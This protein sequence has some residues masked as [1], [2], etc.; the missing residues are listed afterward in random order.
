MNKEKFFAGLPFTINDSNLRP[1]IILV[2]NELTTVIK[3][4]FE[5]LDKD[6]NLSNVT[7]GHS[8]VDASV[9]LLSGYD[10]DFSMDF[11]EEI[12]SIVNS[13]G[14]A[15]PNAEITDVMDNELFEEWMFAPELNVSENTQMIL[16]SGGLYFTCQFE[17]EFIES[18]MFDYAEFGI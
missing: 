10:T 16:T 17:T 15:D 8:V 12:K 2:N 6:P 4:Y 1:F 13:I 7:V 14:D 5:L 11:A 9:I 18:S 3:Q